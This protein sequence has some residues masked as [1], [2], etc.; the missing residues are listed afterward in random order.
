MRA[1]LVLL[2]LVTSA[3]QSSPATQPAAVEPVPVEARSLTVFEKVMRD[4][5]TP[6]GA[7]L[8]R[9]RLVRADPRDLIF[10]DFAPGERGQTLFEAIFQDPARSSAGNLGRV[11]L[12]RA[13]PRDPF[14][15]YF[16]GL[17]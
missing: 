5:S 10:R 1:C 6:H 15:R 11:R 7:N 17:R 16:G 9:V 2:P 8:G 4:A 14:I 12:I 13:D 3:Y